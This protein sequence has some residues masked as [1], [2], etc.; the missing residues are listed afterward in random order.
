MN[1]DGGKFNY[2]DPNGPRVATINLASQLEAYLMRAQELGAVQS[3]D[4]K[5][6]IAPDAARMIEA[7]HQVLAGGEVELHVKRRGSPDIFNEL[8]RRLAQ[9]MEEANAINKAAGF[10]LTASA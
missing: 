1:W 9:G 3:A 8:Q 5:V 2:N 6:E 7:L 4:G 10:Y